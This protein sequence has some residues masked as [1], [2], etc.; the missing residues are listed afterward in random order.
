MSK[1]HYKLFKD[2]NELFPKEMKNN[3]FSLISFPIQY[4][5]TCSIWF[6]G[7]ILVLLSQKKLI[8]DERE[9]IINI[10]NK[11]NEILNIEPAIELTKDKKLEKINILNINEND[12][13]NKNK[14]INIS[15]DNDFIISHKIFLCP[16]LNI[17]QLE[18]ELIILNIK[19]SD[20]LCSFHEQIE[21][22][23]KKIINIKLNKINYDIMN[24]SFVIQEKQIL[25]ME[26]DF[27][28]VINKCESLIEL[29]FYKNDYNEK[30]NIL[31]YIELNKNISEIINQIYSCILDNKNLP[32][33]FSNEALI[34]MNF[35]KNDIFLQILNS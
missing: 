6:I 10:I 25:K 16:F 4:N 35:I 18:N 24:K 23:R 15:K 1:Q 28:Q 34:K 30:N 31:I 29:N 22:I 19:F 2:D 20:I 27:N 33:L 32:I 12:E 21:E 13:Y 9:L 14:I 11:I 7:T 5:N 3:L 26:E 8:E 17:K